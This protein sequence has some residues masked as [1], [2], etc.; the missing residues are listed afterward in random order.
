[1][2]EAVHSYTRYAAMGDTERMPPQRRAS[3]KSGRKRKAPV[4][5]IAVIVLVLVTLATHVLVPWAPNTL[6]GT[7]FG[8]G[9]AWML[10]LVN[11]EHPMG[12]YQP[13]LTELK[14]GQ[15][16]DSRCYP[17]LLR[18]FDAA[19]AAGLRP[20]VNSSYRSREE[21]QQVLD[22]AIAEGVGDGLSEG[23]ARRLALRTVAEPGTS[24]H[25]TGLAIDVT[26]ES[27]T[28][29]DNAAVW[30]WMSEHSW[31]HGWILRYPE[32]KEEIT[33]IDCEPW[34]FRYVGVAAARE[35]HES[36]QCFEEYL[37]QL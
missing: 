13:E 19:R 36:G 23:E 7:A 37:K 32:G 6:S 15:A 34:H 9:D 10:V 14:G 22:D 11:D 3:T 26:S 24:E 5:A 35:M 2:E 25:E 4:A 16:V 33:G 27:Q 31:E 8:K 28:Y 21:Q 29:E 18:M 30:D 12:P 17:D 20:K 1:M